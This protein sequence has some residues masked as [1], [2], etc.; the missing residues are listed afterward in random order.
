[1]AGNVAVDTDPARNIKVTKARLKEKMDNI[2]AAIM[3]FNRCIRNQT[4]PQ[5]SVYDE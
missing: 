2:V 5:G 3:A 1:M 4:E